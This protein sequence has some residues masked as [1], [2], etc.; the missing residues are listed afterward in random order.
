EVPRFTYRADRDKIDASLSR[1]RAVISTD[2]M[3]IATS[4]LDTMTSRWG[5]IN[6]FI[7]E[8]RGHPISLRESEKYI[9]D[10]LEHHRVPGKLQIRW[11]DDLNSGGR[12]QEWGPRG[13]PTKRRLRLWINKNFEGIAF[14]KS[15]V[16]FTD[17]E[18]CTHALRA[19]NDH[20]QVWA[21]NRCKFSLQGMGTRKSAAT[22]EGLASLNA[23]L[24][25]PDRHRYL[26]SAALLYYCAVKGQEMGFRE[27]HEHLFK[28]LQSASKRYW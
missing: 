10:Y 7:E 19:L 24:S 27:L 1:P 28:Y 14:S 15:I 20:V 18:I 8:T 16:S 4:I 3:G 6:N 22:E 25:Y 5:H 26:W 21:N 11:V 12:L 9:E 2:L 23:L 17:H 13:D